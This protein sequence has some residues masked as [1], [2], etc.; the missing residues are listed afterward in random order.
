MKE[1]KEKKKPK[2]GG[3]RKGAGRPCA[4]IDWALFEQLCGIQCTQSELASM[5]KVHHETL[6][7][8]A[9]I[10]YKLEDYGK[11]F[12]SIY[13]RFSEIGKCSLRRYQFIQSKA[14][15]NMAIWLGKQWLGQKEN[16]SE[17]KDL[18]VHELRAGIKQI[19]QESGSEEAIRSVVATESP[20]PDR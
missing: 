6:V 5:L 10:K 9:L 17:L 14:K 15:P 19:S 12:P 13:K 18:I 8:N 11:D 1:K 20:L 3:V 16:V 7:N 4:E 2:T